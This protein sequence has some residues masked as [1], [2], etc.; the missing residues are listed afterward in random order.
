MQPNTHIIIFQE[1]K[2]IKF[3]PSLIFRPS[4]ISARPIWP[5]RLS[6]RAPGP[7]TWAW[8]GKEAS[9]AGLPRPGR[10][11]TRA[12]RRM[13]IRRQSSRAARIKTAAGRVP[14]R[15]LTLISLLPFSLLTEQRRRRA[16]SD[17]GAERSPAR[18]EAAAPPSFARR[19]CVR[20]WPARSSVE[21]RSSVP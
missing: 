15:T 17:S 16:E 6:T 11:P 9:P 5:N 19:R 8:A 7:T 1:K 21:H 4:T 14:P 10:W 2:P 13:H 12:R 3:G 18:R 20:P